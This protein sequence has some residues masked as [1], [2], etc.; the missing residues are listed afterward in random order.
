MSKNVKTDFGLGGVHG[1]REKGVYESDDDMVIISSDVTSFYP[2]LAI[3]NKF[4]PGHF[5]KE[6]FCDQYEWFF[7][8]RKKIVEHMVAVHLKVKP[9]LCEFCNFECARLDNLSLHRKKSHGAVRV[10][11]LQFLAL[12][13]SGKHPYYNQEKIEL[14]KNFLK[15]QE[16]VTR[17]NEFLMRL[18]QDSEETLARL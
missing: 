12:V 15:S 2:N 11:K 16:T 7:N 18:W 17:L 10:T 6:E 9:F 8:E 14:L 5:P 4:S 3:R 1:A 13:E